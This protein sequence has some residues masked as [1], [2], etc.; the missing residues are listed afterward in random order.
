MMGTKED[1]I[2]KRDEAVVIAVRLALM[3]NELRFQLF[4]EDAVMYIQASETSVNSGIRSL[5]YLIENYDA[6][7]GFNT[8]NG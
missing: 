1:L 5:N 2:K 3:W 8:N 4:S 7:R 6:L